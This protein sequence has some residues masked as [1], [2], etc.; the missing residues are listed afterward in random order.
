[1][2]VAQKRR[3]PSLEAVIFDLD[4]TLIDSIDLYHRIIK[5]VMQWMGLELSLS[6]ENLFGSL[7]RGERISD[8][9]FASELEDREITVDR[10]TTKAIQ[11]FRDIF[12]KGNVD[13]IDGVVGLF[14][15]LRH[16]GFS[17]AI[18]TSS[19]SE[20]VVPFLKEK[21]LHSHLVCVLGR[22]EVNELKPS[23]EPLLKCMDILEVDPC[24]AVYVGDS[25]IDIQAGKAAGTGTV[26]VLTGA[27]GLNCLRAAG[28]DAIIESVGDLLT[29]L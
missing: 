22:T 14:E 16:R 24:R 12:S 9:I 2:I 6:K 27:S 18:V 17:L 28:P 3:F 29:V 5:D 10:F 8:L 13:L 20:V 4:G 11:A 1:M 26:G 21:N 19:S 23:P 15:K 25:V 7:S